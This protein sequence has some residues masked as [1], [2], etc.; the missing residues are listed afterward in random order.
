MK[1]QNQ[2]HAFISAAIARVAAMAVLGLAAS[3]QAQYRTG[4]DGHALDHNTQVGSG[5]YNGQVSPNRINQGSINNNINT[6]IVTGNVAGLDYFHGRVREFNANTFQGNTGTAQSDHLNFVTGPTYSPSSGGTRTEQPIGNYGG[7]TPIYSPSSFVGTPPANLVP[8]NNG[9]TLVPAPMIKPLQP[10]DFDSRVD[11]AGLLNSNPVMGNLPIPGQLDV[12]G[13]VDP[14]GNASMYS[15]SPLYGVRAMQTG[16]AEDSFYQSRFGTVQTTANRSEQKLDQSRIQKM[17]DE[18]NNSQLP[19]NEKGNEKGDGKNDQQNGVKPVP[20]A[21]ELKQDSLNNS[22]AGTA[23]LASGQPLNSA[24]KEQQFTGSLNS[25]AGI[26]NQLLIAPAKQS[27]QLKEL[28]RRFAQ[29]KDKPDDLESARRFNEQLRANAQKD[30][31]K[32]VA[33]GSKDLTPRQPGRSPDDDRPCG[34]F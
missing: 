30:T 24:V 33:A 19:D 31:G 10:S 25:G 3:V 28:D 34:G 23:P 20:G 21:I 12:S 5:G 17:R 26:Q 11:S 29:T 18:L 6:N 4:D 27:A 14:S 9:Q 2:K 22:V 16:N 32:D 8:S 15:M 1:H 13:P 7:A